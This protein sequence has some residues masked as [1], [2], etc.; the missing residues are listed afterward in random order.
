MVSCQKL[1]DKGEF[2]EI[3]TQN[4]RFCSRYCLIQEKGNVITLY[5]TEGIVSLGSISSFDAS[6]PFVAVNVP[7]G[8]MYGVTE[9]DEKAV[10][11]VMT[12]KDKLD[13]WFIYN[14]SFQ[15][16]PFQVSLRKYI[17]ANTNHHTLNGYFD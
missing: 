6:I 16:Q 4:A 10:V 15:H 2:Y 11:H 3:E 9:G 8:S 14:N 5:V 13:P 12:K 7:A 1:A 17:C